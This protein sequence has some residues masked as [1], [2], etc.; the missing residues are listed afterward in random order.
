M[1]TFHHDKG[2]LHGITVLVTTRGPE[3]WVGRCDTMVGDAVILLGADRHHAAEDRTPTDEWVRRA[4][5]V[6]VFPRHDRVVLPKGEVEEVRPL[7][8]V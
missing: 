4:S 6:G 7:A 2:E 5:Q 8:D 3:T 1:G